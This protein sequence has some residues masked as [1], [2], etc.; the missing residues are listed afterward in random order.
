[1]TAA[2][3][4]TFNKVQLAF[5]K[6]IAELCN[7]SRPSVKNTRETSDGLSYTVR[8]TDTN[9]YGAQRYL[10]SLG[11]TSANVKST[12]GSTRGD[13]SSD[14]YGINLS[15]PSGVNVTC[16]SWFGGKKP[17]FSISITGTEAQIAAL[18]AEAK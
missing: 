1:M 4:P 16:G 9:D 13:F 15:H 18:T 5:L 10:L 11:F 17:T 8:V 2:A 7:G 14:A 6:T 3:K 12:G